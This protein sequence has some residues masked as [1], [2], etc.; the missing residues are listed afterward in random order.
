MIGD[1]NEAYLTAATGVLGSMLVD[2]GCVGPLLPELRADM[3]LDPGQ[4]TVFEAVCDLFREGR[5]IDG[6]TVAERMGADAERRRWLAGLIEN[7]PTAANAEEYARLLRDASAVLCLR[8]LGFRLQTVRTEDDAR[9]LI[10]QAQTLLIRRPGVEA[11]TFAQAYEDFFRRHAEEGGVEILPWAVPRMGELV[12]AEPG[13]VI[14]L[15]AYPG[16][17][18]TAFALQCAAR[19][20]EGRSVGYYSFESERHRL[21]DRHVARAAGIDAGRIARKALTDEDCEAF[22]RLRRPLAGPDVTLIEA[23]GMSASDVVRHAQSKRYRVIVVDHAQKVRGEARSRGRESEYDRVSGVS[24]ALQSFAVRS[25]TAV[26]LLSQLNRPEKVRYAYKD[27]EGRRRAATVTP[28]PT[29]SSLR[30]SG[31]LEQDADIVFLLWREDED[32]PGDDTRILKVAKN[33]HGRPLGKMRLSFDGAHQSFAY[34]ETRR[35]APQTGIGPRT[36]Q[37]TRGAREVREAQETQE[38]IFTDA[39]DD[40]DLPF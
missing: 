25:G 7:T 8:D 28:P 20:G 37:E 33:R 34:L 30:A 3:F 6:I 36:A 1:P 27:R 29:L 10:D 23:A 38:S 40:G 15:G 21:Y 26:L 24:D 12:Q 5:P 2:S 11:L 32:D 4:R 22:A 9:D 35:E 39:P 13:D 16:T 14:V 31:Q 19:W 17:G 18:K